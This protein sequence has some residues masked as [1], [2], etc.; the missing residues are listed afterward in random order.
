MATLACLLNYVLLSTLGFWMFGQITIIHD[1]YDVDALVLSPVIVKANGWTPLHLAAARGDLP[2]AASLL[3]D[4][5]PVDQPNGN[6]RTALYEASKRG[7]TAVVTLLLNRGANPNARGKLE[8]T[9]AACGSGRRY[10]HHRRP[11]RP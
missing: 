4:G 10:R 5:A 9:S 1:P 11:A 7:R 2:L 6:R 8:A 3:D